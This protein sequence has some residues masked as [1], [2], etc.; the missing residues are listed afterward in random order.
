[1]TPSRCL[2]LALILT[3]PVRGARAADL[4]APPP[5]P[6]PPLAFELADEGDHTGAALEFRRAATEESDPLRRAG[7]YWHAGHAYFQAGDYA[8]AESMLGR[9]EALGADWQAAGLLLRAEIARAAGR[10]DEALFYYDSLIAAP[11]ASDA[12]GFARRARLALLLERRDVSA[13]RAALADWPAAPPAAARA[14]ADYARGRDRS[15]ALGGA[16]G[17]VPGLGYAYAGEY[18]TAL[19]SLI[20][21]SLFLFGMWHTAEEESWGAFAA[22]TFFELTWYSGSIYGGIDASHRHNRRRAE[23]AAL[24]VRGGARWQPD[25]PAAPAVSLTFTY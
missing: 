8:R 25:A 11:P 17:L 12:G 4:A 16:L 3:L 13:A 1:M 2:L 5:A 14:V 19:R 23:R 15:P 10:P 20:L 6:P 22:I 7:W 18:A 24:R 21:N 9:G